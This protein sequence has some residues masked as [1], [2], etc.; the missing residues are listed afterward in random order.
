MLTDVDDVCVTEVVT[1]ANQSCP[2]AGEY[3]ATSRDGCVHRMSVGCQHATYIDI[4]L[5]CVD[6]TA[7]GLTI[8][9]SRLTGVRN[10]RSIDRFI[11]AEL[12]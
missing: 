2:V 1:S 12:T 11:P 8:R 5:D 6:H 10:P 3:Q 4:N 7:P 9:H